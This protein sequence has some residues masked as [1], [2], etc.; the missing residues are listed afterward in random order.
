MKQ[1]IKDFATM[2]AVLGLFT[3]FLTLMYIIR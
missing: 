1:I 2:M 3:L